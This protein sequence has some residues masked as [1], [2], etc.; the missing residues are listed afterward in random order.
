MAGPV[1][2]TA[3]QK[4]AIKRSAEANPEPT[5]LPKRS[6]DNLGLKQQA[7]IVNARAN[8]EDTGSEIASKQLQADL[9]ANEKR[10][11][12]SAVLPAENENLVAVCQAADAEVSGGKITEHETTRDYS[13]AHNRE[14]GAFGKETFPQSVDLQPAAEVVAGLE[15][16][17]KVYEKRDVLAEVLVTLSEHCSASRARLVSQVT[18]EP[19]VKETS[20]TSPHEEV[21]SMVDDVWIE[22]LAKE[23]A[24]RAAARLTEPKTAEA[25]SEM[26]SDTLTTENSVEVVPLQP[27]LA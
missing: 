8:V 26:R 4:Q 21:K 16:A 24:P 6:P 11:P 1:N 22:P 23:A 9:S 2:E 12:F 25:V 3:P 13:K 19:M 17:Q 18:V 27:A 15:G 14:G 10:A 7:R 5:P 20:L